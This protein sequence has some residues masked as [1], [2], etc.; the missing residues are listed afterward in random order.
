MPLAS[1]ISAG[2]VKTSRV[3][4]TVDPHGSRPG[5][6]VRSRPPRQSRRQPGHRPRRGAASAGPTA[7][8]RPHRPAAARARC[9]GASRPAGGTARRQRIS[10]VT[11]RSNTPGSSR[12]PVTVRPLARPTDTSRRGRPIART[13]ARATF[14]GGS[15][16]GGGRPMRPV[17]AAGLG[18]DRG[19]DATRGDQADV[20]PG[21]LP[22]LDLQ[23]AHQAV[24]APLRRDVR[25]H[26]RRAILP[27]REPTRT[28][29]PPPWSPGRGAAPSA[30]RARC[31]AG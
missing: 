8:A 17:Y 27:S 1:G 13:T 30:R 18:V 16:G 7:R 20:D 12:N 14:S 25:A 9:R 11:S 23:G 21:R 5:R 22:G 3:A 19:V 6:A 28:S 26:V 29:R 10:G 24:D 31:R 4:A 15:T 2:G